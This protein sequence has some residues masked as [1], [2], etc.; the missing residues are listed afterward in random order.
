MWLIENKLSAD[1]LSSFIFVE[2][3]YGIGDI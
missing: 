2:H 3:Q 1:F